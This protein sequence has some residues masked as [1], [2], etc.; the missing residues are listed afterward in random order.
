M[1]EGALQH[2]ELHCICHPLGLVGGLCVVPLFQR[3]EQL[4]R[5]W[6]VPFRCGN[7]AYS[8]EDDL[9]LH[10]CAGCLPWL[11]RHKA[12]PGPPGHPEDPSVVFFLHCFGLHPRVCFV[13]QAQPLALVGFCAPLLVAGVTAQ[14]RHL[15][16]GLHCVVEP[17]GDVEGE[18]PVR[19]V[20]ALP[21]P[22]EDLD[23]GII[24]RDLHVA[25]PDLQPLAGH[26]VE[27]E[28][29]MALDRRHLA[30]P[31]PLRLGCDDVPVGPA[32]VQPALRI[33]HAGHR[34]RSRLGR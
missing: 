2:S 34:A 20:V 22:L 7:L 31:L 24:H 30:C 8:A 13:I 6:E 1:V 23:I 11:G 21:A 28:V 19:E 4:W 10:A 33:L 32:Q 25:L 14:R 17:D 16:L 9:L 26:H 5:A 12:L 3:L 18:V 29:P 27:V 15:L